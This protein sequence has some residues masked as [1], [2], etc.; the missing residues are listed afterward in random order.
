[1]VRW[2]FKEVD[3]YSDNR[4]NIEEKHS[5]EE[6]NLYKRERGFDY[7]LDLSKKD[8]EHREKISTIFKRRKKFTKITLSSV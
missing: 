4:I 8:K 5:Y 6:N 2:I 3:G 1:M 7:C